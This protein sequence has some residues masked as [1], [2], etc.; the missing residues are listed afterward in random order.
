MDTRLFGISEEEL[1]SKLFNI[2][3]G[4]S[5]GNKFLNKKLAEEYLRF[6]LAKTKDKVVVLIADEID[7]I[8]WEIFRNFS[9]E[10]AREKVENKSE[11]LVKMFKNIIDKLKREIKGSLFNKIEVI[12][13][14]D[15]KT[16]NFLLSE[17]FIAE[18]YRNNF[19]FKKRILCFVEEYAKV[20]KKLLSDEEKNK[21]TSYIIAELPTLIEGIRYSD[22]LYQIILY[23]T[24]ISS[25]MSKFVLDI[26]NGAYPKLLKKLEIKKPGKMIELYLTKKT[27]GHS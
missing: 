27:N 16:K 2:F 24:Y 23:P 5:L 10:E 12:K 3:I 26:Q 1:N 7:V 9:K 19:G 22:E 20:R 17:K 14:N 13:W 15:V 18:E 21:L 11:D 25:G 6:A 4:I 8:N